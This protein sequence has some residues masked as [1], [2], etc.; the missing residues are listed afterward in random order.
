VEAA[1]GQYSSTTEAAKSELPYLG[2]EGR[3]EFLDA[4]GIMITVAG[5]QISI[6]RLITV[7]TL[8]L[9]QRYKKSRLRSPT[10]PDTD[11]GPDL[12]R[13]THLSGPYGPLFACYER[14]FHRAGCGMIMRL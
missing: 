13:N 2:F 10:I 6:A 1:C 7:R 8:T 11:D 12:L 3:C 9:I 4:A 5:D 14:G